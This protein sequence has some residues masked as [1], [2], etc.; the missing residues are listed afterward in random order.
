MEMLS[1]NPWAVEKEVE[2][3]LAWM[4]IFSLMETETKFDKVA[5]H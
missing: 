1:V 4:L 2:C 5:T 3:V